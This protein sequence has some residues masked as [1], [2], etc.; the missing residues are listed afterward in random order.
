MQGG[1]GQ[2]KNRKRRLRYESKLI[3][4]GV[5]GFGRLLSGVYFM[6]SRWVELGEAEVFHEAAADKWTEKSVW[7]SAESASHGRRP[8]LRRAW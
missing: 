1:G 5:N 6:H 7:S 4:H 3:H 2:Q 8:L